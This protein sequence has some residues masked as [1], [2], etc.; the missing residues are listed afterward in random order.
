MEQWAY[1]IFGVSAAAWITHVFTCLSDDRCG[2]QCVGCFDLG[3]YLVSVIILLL[4]MVW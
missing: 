2:F 4:V 3:V 1:I